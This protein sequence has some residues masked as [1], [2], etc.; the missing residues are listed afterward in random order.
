MIQLTRIDGREI[1][2]NEG[3]ILQVEAT[4]DTVVTLSLGDSVLVR[5]SP[6]E[7]LSRIVAFRR[8][9]ARTGEET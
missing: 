6:A 3:F 2:V 7:V 1:L 4:P 5:E 8:N 9:C